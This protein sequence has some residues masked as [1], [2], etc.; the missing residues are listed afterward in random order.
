MA[1]KLMQ[2][3]VVSVASICLCQVVSAQPNKGV[4]VSMQR[5][6]VDFGKGCNVSMMR[7]RGSDAVEGFVV[8]PLPKAW[9]SS[10]DAIRFFADCYDKDDPFVS[11]TLAWFDS[12]K[13][14]WVR[15]EAEMKKSL[16]KSQDFQDTAFL[17]ETIKAT[18]IYNVQSVNAQ[19]WAMTGDDL[20]GDERGRQRGMSFCLFNPPK[21]LCGGGTVAYL[22]DGRKGDITKYAL[23]IGS[24]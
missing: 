2:W 17:N 13:K 24:V 3:L 19:G 4:S 12:D 22:A 5:K 14:T 23:D 11:Q 20:T 10:L 16:S 6:Q 18:K 21:V 8:D 9:K 15:N 1:S 7:P